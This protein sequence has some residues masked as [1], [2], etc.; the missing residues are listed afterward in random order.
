[1]ESK[2]YEERLLVCSYLKK[3]EKIWEELADRARE[4]FLKQF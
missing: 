2:A 1:M 4:G 3:A